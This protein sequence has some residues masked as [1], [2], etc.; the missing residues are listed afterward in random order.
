[1]KKEDILQAIALGMSAEFIERVL[2]NLI[3]RER[4]SA[5]HRG[6]EEGMDAVNKIVN[7]LYK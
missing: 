2:N 4:S 6:Y 3:E 7:N 1:M 5:Y